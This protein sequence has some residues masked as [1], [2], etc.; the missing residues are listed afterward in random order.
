M[1][2]VKILIAGLALFAAVVAKSKA[3]KS[4]KATKHTKQNKPMAKVNTQPEHITNMMTGHINTNVP[5]RSPMWKNFHNNLYK[6]PFMHGVVGPQWSVPGAE[7][8]DGF[9]LIGSPMPKMDV[10]TR[11]IAANLPGKTYTPTSFDSPLR[12]DV[13]QADM[14]TQIT[15][16]REE[17]SDPRHPAKRPVA[18]VTGTLYHGTGSLDPKVVHGSIPSFIGKSEKKCN[19][20]KCNKKKCTKS[21][22]SKS[23]RSDNK[24][25]AN[26]RNKDYI[27]Q[28]A[29]KVRVDGLAAAKQ[30][31]ARSGAMLGAIG[32][33]HPI[34]LDV[35]TTNKR[36]QP[37]HLHQYENNAYL[38]ARVNGM[39]RSP[40]GVKA[41]H[42]VRRL[43]R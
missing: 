28:D 31:Y 30:A 38:K 1:K 32:A 15:R 7:V 19:K 24:S 20:K 2:I 8:T 6:R 9:N 29:R 5:D 25:K 43:G 17:S 35:H 34:I 23:K 39:R 21:K 10:K 40:H 33:G 11:I 14:P 42:T 26:C 18:K 3:N 27:F 12:K 16:T 22:L 36:E 41:A 13:I 37:D 4:K